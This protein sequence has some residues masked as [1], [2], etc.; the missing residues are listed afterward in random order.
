MI[1]NYTQPDTSVWTL[2]QGYYRVTTLL[3]YFFAIIAEVPCSGNGGCSDTCGV[4][5]GEE[6]CFC[7][8]GFVLLKFDQQ[9]CIGKFTVPSQM[10]C[11]YWIANAIHQHADEDECIFLSPCDQVCTN[12]F[13]SFEC[14]CVDGYVLLDDMTNCGGLLEVTEEYSDT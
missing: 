8:T 10:Y 2:L 5:D 4:I 7:P 13:G 1:R 14:S 12:T 11:F 6:Q 3:V 9:T